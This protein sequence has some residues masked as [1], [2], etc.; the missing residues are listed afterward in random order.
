[1][2]PIAFN[3]TLLLTALKRVAPVLV[4]NPP[5]PIMDSLHFSVSAGQARITATSLEQTAQV[6]IPCQADDDCIFCIEA[7]PLLKLIDRCS[8]QPI[9]FEVA[10]TNVLIVIKDGEYTFPL[11]PVQDFPEIPNY[12]MAEE[13]FFCQSGQFLDSLGKVS[14]AIGTN[15]LRPAMTHVLQV[16]DLAGTST[17]IATDAHRLA[18]V[19]VNEFCYDMDGHASIYSENDTPISCLWSAAAAKAAS[20]FIKPGVIKVVK[21]P[22]FLFIEQDEDFYAFQQTDYKFPEASQVIPAM[23]L[24]IEHVDAAMLADIL[25]RVS[26]VSSKEVTNSVKLTFQKN[27]LLLTANDEL[28]DMKGQET[29][30]FLRNTTEPNIGDDIYKEEEAA[31]ATISVALNINSLKQ[32]ISNLE[33][34]KNGVV[35]F[36]INGKERPLV[37]I[38]YDELDGEQALETHLIMPIMLN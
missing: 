37:M 35:Q 14:Y 4:K 25:D 13:Y 19:W 30:A 29:I 23:P 26:V 22:T 36:Q 8:E 20:K 28:N 1:M 16:T 34:Q 17:F 11:F 33:Y 15:E 2:T 32:A 27:K 12:S 10:D 3:R 9:S 38:S 18:K 6:T 21:T 7:A 31:R 24:R 5:L